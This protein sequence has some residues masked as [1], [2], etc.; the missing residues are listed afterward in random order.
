[1]FIVVIAAQAQQTQNVVS[2]AFL[3]GGNPSDPNASILDLFKDSNN[4]V[5]AVSSILIHAASKSSFNPSLQ[6]T[7][8]SESYNRFISRI[9]R[10]PGLIVTYRHQEPL[11]LDGSNDQFF[12]VV[13]ATYQADVPERVQEAFGQ[14]LN[15]AGSVS[16]SST[17]VVLTHLSVRPAAYSQ[18][19][20][21]F[22]AAVELS[23]THGGVHNDRVRIVPQRTRLVT[24]ELSSNATTLVDN[25]DR[26]AATI[27]K[28]TAADLI[29]YFSTKVPSS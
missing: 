19:V 24:L 13:S 25:A 8:D 28:N 14:L 21:I 6:G 7:E 3:I 23:V 29:S 15:V 22:V 11:K 20:S 2:G 5:D 12:K 17:K 16:T 1:M 26:L 27:N 9:T 4:H 10:F 18:D